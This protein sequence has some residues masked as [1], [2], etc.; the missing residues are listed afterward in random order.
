MQTCL[1]VIFILA[2]ARAKN[3]IK[4]QKSSIF[5]AQNATKAFPIANPKVAEAEGI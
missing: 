5:V 2:L 4:M 1:F 3:T